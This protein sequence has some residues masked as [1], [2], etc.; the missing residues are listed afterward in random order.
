M[1]GK[2]G[3]LLAHYTTVE[4]ALGH[5][6]PTGRIRLSPYTDMSDPL[7]HKQWTFGAGHWGGFEGNEDFKLLVELSALAKIA[8]ETTKLV[9][10]TQDAPSGYQ[11]VAETF[12]RGYGRARMWQQYA[13]DHQG[14]CLLFDRSEIIDRMVADLDERGD[15][16]HGA[17]DY[18]EEGLAGEVQARTLV[19]ENFKENTTQ[20]VIDH[21][22]NH[23]RE[24]FFLKTKD[25]ETECEYRFVVSGFEHG[26]EYVEYEGAL[27]AVVAGEK[28]PDWQVPAVRHACD[29]QNIEALEMLWENDRPWTAA[30]RTQEEKRRRRIRRIAQAQVDAR[31]PASGADE[32]LNKG[33]QPNDS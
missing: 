3:E 19:L 6:L 12:G 5:I 31:D 24:L 11:G 33:P 8:K 15:V 10:L 20:A 21:I 18:T 26:Y 25:W 30:L 7:E 23:Y 2:R 32:K 16:Y 27:K 17:V 28:L 4:A 29:K 22:A 14:V 13:S 9:A 1:Y